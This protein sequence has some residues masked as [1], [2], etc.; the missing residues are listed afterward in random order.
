MG[1]QER[2]WLMM[3]DDAQIR[4]IRTTTTTTARRARARTG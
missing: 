4:T 3:E 2:W 1:L